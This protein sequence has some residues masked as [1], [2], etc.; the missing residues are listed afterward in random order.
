MWLGA[1]VV[2]PAVP[3]RGAWVGEGV[4]GTVGEGV[5]DAAGAHN[6]SS[7]W[8][9][10]G[11]FVGSQLHSGGGGGEGGCR[12]G[13]CV[14]QNCAVGCGCTHWEVEQPNVK[15]QHSC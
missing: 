15:Q 13:W 7:A 8:H 10:I 6:A 1:G 3:V 14:G 4:V 12:L 5:G 9:I 2:G 11:R